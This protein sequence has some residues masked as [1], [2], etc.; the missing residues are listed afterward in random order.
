M[1]RALSQG[2]G[3]NVREGGGGGGGGAQMEKIA[4]FI[5]NLNPLLEKTPH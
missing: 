2:E 1:T 5:P 4:E 3:Y